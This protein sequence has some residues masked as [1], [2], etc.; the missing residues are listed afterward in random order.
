MHHADKY[1]CYSTA[2]YALQVTQLYALGLI[3]DGI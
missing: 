3:A 2:I 1:I